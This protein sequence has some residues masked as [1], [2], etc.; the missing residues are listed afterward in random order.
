MTGRA[1]LWDGRRSASR[2]I[3]GGSP[4]CPFQ[5]DERAGDLAMKRGWTAI[6][7]A[8]ERS[9]GGWSFAP[10]RL[11]WARVSA[12]LGRPGGTGN[13]RVRA[14]VLAGVANRWTRQDFDGC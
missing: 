12:R 10:V 13:V 5:G 6:L 9:P 7:E 8:P 2:R 4:E 1:G 3:M 11:S 14:I